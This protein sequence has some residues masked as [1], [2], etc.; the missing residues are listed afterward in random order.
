VLKAWLLVIG[1]SLSLTGV[2]QVDSV[3][4]LSQCIDSV[5]KY[6]FR[7]QAEAFNTEA[8]GKNLDVSHTRSLPTLTGDV[9]IEGRSLIPYN[10]GQQWTLVH[11]DWSLGDFIKKTDRV[12]RQEVVTAQLMQEQV[13]LDG[14]SRV[15]SLFMNVLQ[16]EKERELL[17]ERIRLLGTHRIVAVSLWKAGVRTRLDILQTESELSVAKE[18]KVRILV[19]IRN[20]IKEI[21]NLTGMTMLDT[22]QLETIN[23]KDLIQ[24][25]NISELDRQLITENP[26]Y[27]VL[28][29]KVQSRHL[30]TDLINAQKWPHIV[31]GGGYFVD[32]DPTSDGNYWTIQAGI[33]F[34]IYQWGSINYQ[35]EES[36]ALGKSLNMD[37]L[38]LNR[39]LL[40]HLEKTMIRLEEL[41]N[42]LELQETRLE[43]LQEAQSLADIN[44]KAGLITNLEYLVTQQR[45]TTTMITIEETR[46][47]YILNLIEYYLVTNQVQKIKEMGTFTGTTN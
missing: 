31:A 28:L 42:M 1:I 34:P 40:I 14:I 13:R 12:A 44:Y 45:N 22:F 9:G 39:E 23:T 21:T 16:K 47:E 46:L 4:T 30:Q 32:G 18:E 17:N 6:S 35:K 24:Q 38:D 33:A 43:T 15:T 10:F 27:Q 5:Q 11:G 25:V 20:A 41:R 7:L 19:E 36:E 3:I 29:S 2:S 8:A 26:L 37:L